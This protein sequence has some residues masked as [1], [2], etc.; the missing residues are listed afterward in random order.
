MYYSGFVIEYKK[1]FI[2]K[3]TQISYIHVGTT[4]Y[5]NSNLGKKYDIKFMTTYENVFIEYITRFLMS[6]I[7]KICSLK[8]MHKNSPRIANNLS[9]NMKLCQAFQV[10]NYFRSILITS[11]LWWI[12]CNNSLSV[13]LINSG[14]FG[15]LFDLFSIMAIL[16]LTNTMKYFTTFQI[17]KVFQE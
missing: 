10:L 6:Y 4:L 1:L 8:W 7:L 17:S 12:C 9:W 11:Y 14:N 16:A 2:R 3:A 15:P 13:Y 5:N